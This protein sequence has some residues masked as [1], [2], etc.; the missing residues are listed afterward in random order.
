MLIRA[1]KISILKSE[2]IGRVDICNVEYKRFIMELKQRTLADKQMVFA[3]KLKN[4]INI[5]K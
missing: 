5:I 4:L 1:Y 2:F 3:V